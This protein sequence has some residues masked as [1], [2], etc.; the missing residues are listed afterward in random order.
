MKT[1]TR[2]L[3]LVLLVCGGAAATADVGTRLDAGRERARRP[4]RPLGPPHTVAASTIRVHDGDTFYTGVETIRLRGIDTPELGRPGGRAAAIRLAELLR[5]G[6]VTIVPRAEDVYGRTVADV[7][8]RGQNVA[9]VLR[10]EGFGKPG[11]R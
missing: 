4:A 6:P 5:E 8:V 11:G 3:A 9:D 1:T 10:R 7:Y 2:A